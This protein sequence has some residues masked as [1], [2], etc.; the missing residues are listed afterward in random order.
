MVESGR[1]NTGFCVNLRVVIE[2]E[3]R[4]LSKFEESD[5]HV[6]MVVIIYYLKID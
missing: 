3:V 2:T 5:A 4:Y 6:I 1:Q